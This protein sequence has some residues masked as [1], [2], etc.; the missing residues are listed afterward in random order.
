MRISKIFGISFCNSPFLMSYHKGKY[1][2]NLF[3]RRKKFVG[4]VYKMYKFVKKCK[5]V[6]LELIHVFHIEK[7][8]KGG[9]NVA[10]QNLSTLST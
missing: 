3:T 8:E 2:M 7:A 6:K 10:F 1:L 9:K 5:K 4:W